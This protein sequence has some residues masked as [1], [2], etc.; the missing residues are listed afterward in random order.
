MEFIASLIKKLF[1]SLFAKAAKTKDTTGEVTQIKTSSPNT[2]VEIQ[3]TSTSSI[4]EYAEENNTKRREFFEPIKYKNDNSRLMEEHIDLIDKNRKLYG[5]L[6]ELNKFT[7]RRFKKPILITMIYRTQ[8]EQDFLYKNNTRYQKKKFISPH[9]LWHSVDIRSHSFTASEIE[10]IEDWIN[11]KYDNSN[12]YKWTA[13]FHTV[14]HG[15][16]LH[17]QFVEK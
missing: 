10:E 11:D 13:K 2:P 5:M 7:N 3:G 12:Y 6:L 8:E 15:K 4:E 9:Q 16:H 17:L 14:G 1:Q